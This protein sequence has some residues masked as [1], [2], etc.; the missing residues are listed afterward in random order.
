MQSAPMAQWEYSAPGPP[1]SH[2]P[3]LVCS[4]MCVPARWQLL[5]HVHADGSGGASG[6][7]SDADESAVATQHTTSE[8]RIA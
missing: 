6:G 8:R 1:S 5:T 7:G 2:R 3:S 4:W